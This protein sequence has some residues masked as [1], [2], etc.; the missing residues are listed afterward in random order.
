MR[1]GA[2]WLA[3]LAVVPALAGTTGA[4]WWLQAQGVTPRLLGPWIGKRSEGH[5]PVITH[6][7][8]TLRAALL[9]LDRGEP[10]P[11]V[12]PKL[13]VGAQPQPVRGEGGTVRTVASSDEARAAISNARAGDIITFAPGAYRFKGAALA[14]RAAGTDAVPVIVRAQQPGTVTLEFDMG[15]GVAVS[16]PH[17]RFENLAIRGV[18]AR[19]AQ[20]EH[21]FHVTGRAHHFAALNN[22]ITDF[23]AHFKVNGVNGAFPD[24]GLIEGNTISNASVRDTG[25]PVTPID[26]VAATGWTIR[27]NLI[28]DFVKG[29]GDR[30]SYGAFAKGAGARTT[31][32]R[33]VV[34]CE[35]LLR[36]QPGARVGLSL[37]GG[38]TGKRF[39]RDGRCVTE[40]EE[41]VIRDNL[42]ASCSDAGIYANSA[43]RT[44]VSHNTLLDTAGIDLRFPETSAQVEGNLVDGPIRSRNGARLRLTENEETPV[45]LLY[46]GYHPVRRMFADA[47]AFDLAWRTQPPRRERKAGSPD[48]CAAI[49]PA[50]A[51]YGAFEDFTACLR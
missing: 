24:H 3:A 49:R 48:L 31:F 32:E 42:I 26:I 11:Y 25:S 40:H 36:G 39:C 18:C 41:G 13:A 8:S 6:T 7:G 27:G 30:I 21:A 46:A 35:Q 37:G 16:G 10:Q 34:I 9:A 44:L 2:L 47:G 51:R 29:G 5:N 50:Q 19:H 43:A 20:C 17:W 12:L 45:A 28:T 23:N 22:R 33:N 4:L 38:G 15:E 1:Q 14:A